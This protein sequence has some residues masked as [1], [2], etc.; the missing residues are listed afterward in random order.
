MYTFILDQMKIEL[1]ERVLLNDDDP[2]ID[3]ISYYDYD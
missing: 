3:I 1:S 2:M